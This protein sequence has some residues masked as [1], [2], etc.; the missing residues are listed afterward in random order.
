MISQL[1]L[2]TLVRE[3]RN[4][5]R[6]PVSILSI[7]ESDSPMP[8]MKTPRSRFLMRPLMRLGQLLLALI[9][10]AI[11]WLPN[12]TSVHAAFGDFDPTFG[13]GGI[14]AIP[15]QNL[16]WSLDMARQ[17]DGKVLV[18][19]YSFVDA[20]GDGF[21]SNHAIVRYNTNGTLDTTFGGD[22]V[23]FT[24]FGGDH[25]VTSM[26]LQ[27]DGKIVVAGAMYIWPDLSDFAV[28]RYNTNGTID[29]TFGGG[30]G[31]VTVNS[32]YG[33]YFF[34]VV[35]QT[36][37]KIVAGGKVA[38]AESGLM[39]FNADG[40]LDT[41]FSSDGIVVPALLGL[42]NVTRLAMQSDGKLVVAGESF[43]VSNGT[44]RS[45]RFLLARYNSNG[46]LDTTFDGD[47]YVATTVGGG[48][49]LTSLLVQPGDKI[50]ATGTAASDIAIVRYNTNGTPD[51]TFGGDGIVNTDL[52]PASQWERNPSLIVQPNGKYVVGA[53]VYMAG[54]QWTTPPGGYFNMVLLK[55]NADGSL[56]TQFANNGVSIFGLGYPEH[57]DF[58]E[59]LL[60]QPDGK[61]V[62]AGL[63][64]DSNM[65]VG[66][67]E[68]ESPITLANSTIVEN[69][70]AGTQ[71][72]TLTSD[73]SAGAS[74]FTYSLVA[75]TGSTDNGSFSIVGN[76]LRSAA[77][78]NFE[79]K[80]TYS[81][82]IRSTS[83]NSIVTERTLTIAVINVNEAPTA[84]NLS[85][86]SV[87]EN[88]SAGTT[89]GTLSTTDPDAGNTHTYSLVTG[90]GSTDNA[91]FT[92][93]GN[94][95]RSAAT[96]N[97]E[98]K[99]SYSIRVRSTDQSG[100]TFEQVFT[101]SVTN[102]NETP[103]ALALSTSTIAENSAVATQV[104]TLSTT[105]PDSGNTHTY[106]LVS[107]TGSTDN[108]SFTIVGNAL[109]SAA[110][111]NFET[112]SSYSIRIRSTDQ[113]GLFFEQSFT[114]SVSNV[115]E[116][117]TNLTLSSSTVAEN[118][119]V[120]TT[121]GT[122]STT[123][124]DTANTHTYSLVA[125]TGSTDNASFTIS[126]NLL[127]SAAIFNFEAKSSYSV[128]IRSTDQGGL[129]FERSFTISVSNVNEAPTALNLSVSTIAENA[130][131]GTQVG[132]LSSTDADTANTHTYTLVT[133]TGSTDNAS[134]TLVGN[135]LRSA[136]IF[137]FEA[138]SSYSVRIRS[139]DQGGLFFERSFTITVTNVNET[140]SAL[141]LS[142]N[143]IA[144][145]AAVG[146]QVGM[147]STTDPD[148]SNTHTYSL[149]AGTG[150]TDNASFTILGNALR[151]AATFNFETKSSYSIRIRST[152]QGGLFF[153][154]SFTIT[155]TNVNETP[156][157]LALSGSTITENSAVGT[158]VGTLSSTDPDASGTYIYTLVAG[159][160][161]TD[162]ASFTITGS[163]LKSAAIFNFE[164]KSSYSIRIRTTDQ[165]G[166]F[167]E[168]SFTIT[169]SN[170]NEAPTNLTL[171]SSSMAE[172]Q[173]AGTT[174]GTL[175][176]TD[177]DAA[178][179]HTYSLVAGT[180]ST[181]NASF[182]IVGNAL[183]S[184]AIFN[185]ETKSSY[186]VRIRSTD[187]GNL[188]FEQSFTITVTNVN[189]T[190]SALALSASTI[191]ENSAVGTSVGT[192]STTDPD[193][194]NTHTYSLVAG[195]GST[196]NASFTIVGNALRSAAIFNFETKSS[197][198]IRIRSTDQG[199]LFFEQSF[200]ISVSNVNETPTALNLSRSSLAENQ[201]VGTTIGTLSTTDPDASNTHT[202]SLVAGTGSTDNASFTIVGNA[203]KSAAI[204]NFEAK[205]SYSIRVR[206]TDQ[207]N[208]FFERSFT[209]SVSNVNEAP[210]ALALTPRTLAE[211]LPVNTT[212][213]TLSTTD[214][215]TANTF[216]YALVAGSGDT[217]N[218]LFT[219]SGNLLK[220][221]TSFDFETQS[222]Y[223]VRIRSTDQGGLQ[224]AAEFIITISDANDAATAITLDN[225]TLV[226]NASTGTIVGMLAT[227]DVDTGDTHTY[228]VVAGEGDTDNGSFVIDGDLLKSATSFNFETKSTFSIR[229]QST[230]SD[231]EI[232]TAPFSI[233]ILDANDAPTAITLDSQSVD[234]N[235]AISVT[236]G[237]L[238]TSDEDS[239]NVHIYTLVAGDG[240]TGNGNFVIDGNQLKTAASF[241]FETQSSYSVRVR[242]DD[243]SGEANATLE[244][245]FVI[246][247]NDRNESPSAL[248]L[249]AST[250]T[251]NAAIGT[252]VGTLTT[253][254][255]DASDTYTYTL[256]A[257]SGSTD[258]ASFDIASG[259]LQTAVSFDFE[260]GSNFSVRIRTTDS[261]GLFFEQ[262]FTITVTNVNEVPVALAL[263]A[264]TIAENVAVGTAVGTLTTTDLDATGSYT[265]TLVAGEGDTDN[266][267]FVIDGD[268][269]K[270]ATSF[271]FETKNS[272]SVRVRTTDQGGLFFERS[273]AI[274]VSNVNEAPTTLLLDNTSL[275]E[276]QA[277]GTLVGALT[278]TDPD[279]S[280]THTYTLVAGSGDTDNASFVIDGSTLKSNASFDFE[281]QSSYTVRIRS[282]DQGGLP[283][284][285]EFIVTISDANEAATA[286]T[287]DNNTV[288]ENQSVGVTI[289][290]LTTADVD[291][292]DVHTYTLVAGEG[293]TDNSSAVI[294]GS[295]L[296]SAVS[297]NFETKSSYSVRVRSTDQGGLQVEA[298][299]IIA[300]SNVNEAPVALALAPSA[301]E[302]N[303]PV[304]TSVGTLTT[305][306][307]DAGDTHTYTLVAGEGD[308]DNA[309]FIL[310]GSTLKSNASFDFESQSSYRVRVRSTDIGGLHVD[311]EFE[312]IIL[313]GTGNNADIDTDHDG[314]ADATDAFPLDPTESVDTDGDG[315]GNN[316]DT[317]DDNDGVA[318]E[319]DAF[320]LD[321]TESVD[322]DDD[323]IGNNADT[324][325]DND[326]VADGSDA[327]PLDPSESVDTDG[328]NIGNNTDT[329]DDNDGVADGSDAF[330]LD[331]SESIDT[332]GDTIGNNTDTDDDNDG[333][334]DEDD[335]FPLNPTESVDTDS[336]ST[337]NNADTD[338]D[339]DGVTDED[340]AFPVDPSESIDTDSDGIGNN[341]DTDD[342][343]DGV[344]DENDAFPLDPSESLDT[345]GD[346]TGNNADTDD[347]NDGVADSADNCPL[348]TNADQLDADQDGL[349]AVCDATEG[350][351]AS[352]ISLAPLDADQTEG[353]NGPLAFTFVVNRTGDLTD[354]TT[355]NYAVSGATDGADFAGGS[356][357]AGLITFNSGQ[358]SQMLT[359]DVQ[360]D[361]SPEE[362]EAFTVT[363]SNA[364]NATIA[365]ATAAGVIRNDD[366]VVALRVSQHASV[367]LARV[368][369]AVT[370]TYLITNTGDVSMTAL[371]AVDDR[372]DIVTLAQNTLAPGESTTG[373]LVHTV[374]LNDLPGPLVKTVTVTGTPL[375]GTTVVVT[376]N[377]RVDVVY[378]AFSFTATV[379]I[380]GIQ[381]ECTA[382]STILVPISTTIVYCFTVTNTG[383]VTLTQHTLEDDLLGTV[384][385]D[386]FELAPGA[387]FSISVPHQIFA[388]VTNT[389]VWMANYAGSEV[390]SD[391][392]SDTESDTVQVAALLTQNSAQASVN[393][394]DD[395][396]DQDGDGI[397]D[398]VE[399]ADDVD[400]DNKPNFLDEDSDGDDRLDRIECTS[401]PCADSN[402]DGNP[403]FLDIINPTNL[404]PDQQPTVPGQLYLPSLG[405]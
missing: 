361:I 200:T 164:T 105:D 277:A 33:D 300:V 108:A 329:D 56:D 227:A 242:S 126:G 240:D 321:P 248:A 184:A 181:D 274:T 66:R 67:F 115:N 214:P 172:N 202:Y 377:A 6:M 112:K 316:A 41:T 120:G 13:T 336:D 282:T 310:E 372:L 286:L 4:P 5:N 357:P 398:N 119:S 118:Q 382:S 65:F 37:G 320:P 332:D 80:S 40:T 2:P 371:S 280:G 70:A 262:N 47:G 306:D 390:A 39:R 19:G 60:L 90:T 244:A 364:S 107:G 59:H 272:Y 349:G 266:S 82:R 218:G 93:V 333:V 160:G 384:L 340:D 7:P 110:I 397:P 148:A 152:D 146:T 122:L 111:F 212:I 295:T 308:T 341:A 256:V 87:A 344:A 247:V 374:A 79:A 373:Q 133:G 178:N 383:N 381:P 88:Q 222:S 21:D 129:F 142:A 389:A 203:L 298:A 255:P 89:I 301:L 342:D 335:A 48:A 367:A 228:T 125:G 401:L 197:Y 324:D 252:A 24:D 353:N 162:N 92:L 141:V 31:L 45:D 75:G 139:T 124:P 147:L 380:Q 25:S 325:D 237:S 34:D 220:S 307:V 151:S 283:V 63:G 128:R 86:N 95:L 359:L 58:L 136:A 191:A 230:G 213:G 402:D 243:G 317:D 46:S 174:I 288:A 328:D 81:I 261:G 140:P 11:V 149:V 351:G 260:T 217:N 235:E 355:V 83:S 180:G 238:D 224:V 193:A 312:I 403:D 273:F 378:A 347:D 137:N 291:A 392:E 322:T 281:S 29:T 51:T 204:F 62:G 198:S 352:M 379:G 366:H 254:D 84:I 311:A 127:K 168:R 55:Y 249:D 117:P 396:S 388:S 346:G 43:I 304:A 85:A 154:Q 27:A 315:T 236:V 303:L 38:I 57:G 98:T 223:T 211:N 130:A 23:V 156:T 91:S 226:E 69:A 35:V 404:D 363:L 299:F 330:P 52:S 54:S 263:D 185:F 1:L 233:T 258:N 99:S 251:E 10:A 182:T 290:T 28:A 177:P 257:G 221:A 289:G 391:A 338:D 219:I 175:S 114:I 77:V 210:T 358:A 50:I 30:D 305:T 169:V 278:T 12:P 166:L 231:G 179:S 53:A 265:Y 44:G 205:S 159:T 393:I 268:L 61:I 302:E 394:A 171:T 267:S 195:T 123:D 101:I 309:S 72:G 78:F 207:G 399:Q 376:A 138:K 49:F 192:L 190:P 287:L 279:A 400:G 296:K 271:N 173:S 183:K 239:A 104:G 216:T 334:A 209:I 385:E 327:F 199:N 362:D 354:I 270:S 345:D 187:Q 375:V 15:G 326:G 241:N 343:N 360:G 14:G 76:S 73:A 167:F 395:T 121:I 134:F 163:T 229:I 323:N 275:I 16:S 158:S 100:L 143:T 339:N 269:L 387:T 234:E 18:L 246:Q 194:A 102:V 155:V 206:S 365:V 368:G 32:S 150:S 369:E 294:D 188:F 293:D 370:Y 259:A 297:F 225:N 264:S 71:V 113:G 3:A 405:R 20:P 201:S 109:R 350:G 215:D 103:S 96:F 196:D 131:V 68:G 232:L 189:E 94:A 208:L 186:S 42:S 285:A 144:E 245:T 153:E 250:V 313:D 176:S 161:S 74:P 17:S 386:E 22:G 135:A 157:A 8:T 319:D 116:T 26:A 97:F 331:P 106:S 145:N 292:G 337:G 314:V 348:L 36:D 356:L 165:G 318:D 9:L 253:V 170:A 284:E 276:N 64:G 132:T